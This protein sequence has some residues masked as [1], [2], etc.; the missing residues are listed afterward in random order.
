MRRFAFF[1]WILQHVCGRL[2]YHGLPEIQQFSIH[3]FR[4]KSTYPDVSGGAG[5]ST[6]LVPVD[7]VVDCLSLARE[8]GV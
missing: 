6:A 8:R 1:R 4:V 3:Y 7:T 5:C 2:Q